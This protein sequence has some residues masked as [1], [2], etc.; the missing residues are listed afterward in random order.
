MI[1]LGLF[2]ISLQFYDHWKKGDSTIH[3]FGKVKKAAVVVNLLLYH[4]INHEA[5]GFSEQPTT[6]LTE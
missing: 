4:V 2:R 6:G 3:T 5:N 1:C